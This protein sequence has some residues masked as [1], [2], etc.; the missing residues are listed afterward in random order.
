MRRVLLLAVLLLA[1]LLLAVLLLAVLLLTVLLLTT[2]VLPLPLALLAVRLAGVRELRDEI[3]EQAHDQDDVAKRALAAFEN[4]RFT[5]AG[6]EEEN[7]DA[8]TSDMRYLS[9]PRPCS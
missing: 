5:S 3:T 4:R 7:Q 6:R 9:L 1:V 8:A 2:A